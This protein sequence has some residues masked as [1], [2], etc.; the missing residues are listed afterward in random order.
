MRFLIDNAAFAQAAR[1]IAQIAGR[2][3]DSPVL[4]EAGPKG[5]T[6][7][8]GGWKQ[9]SRVHC[10]AQVLDEGH[11][12]VNALWL[13]GIAS[14]MP[15]GEVTVRA[16][17]ARLRLESDGAKALMALMDRSADDVRSRLPDMSAAEAGMVDAPDGVLEEL[18]AL[19][20]PFC[21]RDLNSPVLQATHVTGDDGLMRVEATDKFRMLRASHD[22]EGMPL[23]DALVDA[24]WLKAA[25]VGATRVGAS[26]RLFLLA[27]EN[28]VDACVV[29]DGQYPLLNRVMV[30]REQARVTV[31][32]DRVTLMDIIRRLKATDYSKRSFT[33]IRLA[34]EPDRMHVSLEGEE[35][36]NERVMPARLDGAASFRLAFNAQFLL[37]ALASFDG[38]EVT[39]LAT[40]PHKPV[41]FTDGQGST[42]VSVVPLRV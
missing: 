8:G 25:S 21:S 24:T 19:A 20:A 30:S 6:L 23:V 42:S 11:V 3:D 14:S 10:R 16:E 32:F 41:W 36:D 29:M 22:V 27:D 31:A 17:D 28:R 35:L 12:V 9:V 15:N 2:E 34:V 5:V 18:A 26:D 1:H 13:A 38:A 39:L 7:L 40:D 37:D 33:T 4:V